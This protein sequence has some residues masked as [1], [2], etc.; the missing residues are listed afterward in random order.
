[1]I[2]HIKYTP[3]RRGTRFI[4]TIE[5]LDEDDVARDLTGL[6]FSCKGR[7]YTGAP[8][9]LCTF[10]VVVIGNPTDGVIS[11]ELDSASTLAP[12]LDDVA[13]IAAS[14][15]S[16]GADG[17]PVEELTFDLPLLARITT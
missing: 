7:E 1:M 17:E 9:E 2:P 16:I 6:A 4:E 8:T 12:A 3:H 13:T 5:M 10:A 14:L 15:I 11:I